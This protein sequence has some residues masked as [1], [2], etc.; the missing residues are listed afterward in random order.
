[1]LQ[2]LRGFSKRSEKKKIKGRLILTLIIIGFIYY[3]F[4]GTYG[5]VNIG[6]LKIQEKRLR[7]EKEKLIKKEEA[8][9]D[10][11]RK[12]KEDNFFLEKEAREKLGMIKEGDTV[13]IFKEEQIIK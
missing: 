10:S 3:L 9:I 1:M 4:F 7:K 11:L 13:I 6:K 2:N 5:F 12:I 8:L